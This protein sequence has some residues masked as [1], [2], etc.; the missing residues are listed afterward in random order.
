MST[1]RKSK[2]WTIGVIL[3]IVLIGP[4]IGLLMY[5]YGLVFA[6]PWTFATGGMY[7]FTPCLG[8]PVGIIAVLAKWI[9]KRQL[10]VAV[11]VIGIVMIFYLAIIGP[12]LPSGM[13]NCQPI[14]ST[15]PQVRYACVSTSSDNADYRYEFTL[16]GRVGWPVMRIVHSGP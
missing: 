7:V 3:A 8:L 10:L 1:N 15:P 14:A 5:S 9:R 13:T 2:S 11:V 4:M 6:P 16:E 12:G